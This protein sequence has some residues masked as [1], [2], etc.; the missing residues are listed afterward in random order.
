[1]GNIQEKIDKHLIGEAKG[2]PPEGMRYIGVRCFVEVKVIVPY[3][4]NTW[5]TEEAAVKKAETFMKKV[6]NIK[7]KDIE[8]LYSDA[9]GNTRWITD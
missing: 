4:R 9:T 5:K 8:V 6:K 1:M 3:N 7:M 2:L